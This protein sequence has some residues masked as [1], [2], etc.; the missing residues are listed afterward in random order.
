MDAEERSPTSLTVE[1]PE[2]TSSEETPMFFIAGENLLFGVFTRP[3]ARPLGVA[4]ISAAGGMRGTSMGRNRLMVRLSRQAARRGF[5]GLRFDYHGVGES[6]G[7]AQSFSM[8][9]PYVDDLD[10]AARAVESL[11]VQRHVYAGI[12][13]GART[14]MSLAQSRPGAVGVALI[15]PPIR[16]GFR[17]GRKLTR[18]GTGRL[19]KIAI[20]P[21]VLTGLFKRERRAYYAKFLAKLHAAKSRDVE[22]E[23]RDLSWVSA[24]F[25]DPLQQFAERGIPVLIVYGDGSENYREFLRARSGRLGGVLRSAGSMIE[26]VTLPG[27]IHGFSDLLS[28]QRVLDTVEGWA[29]GI[30]GDA[31]REVSVGGEERA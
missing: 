9:A 13:F 4:L 6:A 25:L 29:T 24:H 12:C 30:F 21:S 15:E 27:H 18:Y 1:V 16:D 19:F 5:H 14:V 20:R 3:T 8:E 7:P 2:A 31:R 17:E 26:V 28:Q 11:G 22:R 23:A 10:G